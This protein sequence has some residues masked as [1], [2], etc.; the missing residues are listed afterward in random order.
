M[1]EMVERRMRAV[2]QMDYDD[3]VHE[4]KR[5]L[6]SADNDIPW[7][8]GDLA[9]QVEKRYGESKLKQFA[10]DIGTALCTVERRRSVARAWPKEAARPLFAVAKELQAL[11]DRVE[12]FRSNPNITSREANKLKKER[13]DSSSTECDCGPA[14]P[15]NDGR[16]WVAGAYSRWDHALGAVQIRGGNWERYRDLIDQPARDKLKELVRAVL[17]LD[18][19]V[20]GLFEPVRIAAE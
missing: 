8:I 16:K 4:A 2:A 14:Q 9:D 15:E 19:Y 6:A 13:G 11:D 18:A 1:V 17:D 7:R 5:L 20:D 12:I 3:A 10:E